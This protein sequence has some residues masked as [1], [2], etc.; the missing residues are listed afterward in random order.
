MSSLPSLKNTDSQSI[1]TLVNAAGQTGL[2]L[3]LGQKTLGG[4]LTPKGEA[5]AI[6]THLDGDGFTAADQVVLAAGVDGSTIRKLTVD[7]SG[8]LILSPA[9]SVGALTGTGH[10]N[11]AATGTAIALRSSTACVS[12][13]VKADAANAGTIFV[14]ISTVTNDETAGTGGLQLEPGES[15]G[16]DVANVATVFINGTAGDGA[17]FL[18]EV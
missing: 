10:K 18:W 6:G 7:S 9:S 12:V 17:S 3:G 13:V 15:I 16:I 11:I 5:Q 4:G 1:D 2:K 8:R 14:G